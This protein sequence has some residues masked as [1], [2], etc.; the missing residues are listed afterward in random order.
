MSEPVRPGAVVLFGSGENGPVG[1]EA[2]RWLRASERDPRSVV[3]LETPA[4]FEVNA[5]AVAGKWARFLRR[6][7]ELRRAEVEQIPA[8]RRGTPFTPDDPD[9]ARP[10][11]GADLVVLGAG[12]PTYV[13]RQLRDS[14]AWSNTIA[15]HLLG[16][17]LFLASAAAVAAG[18]CALPVYEIYK[19]GEDPH[20][21]EGLRLFDLYGLRLAVVTHWDNAEGGTG[22]DTS[23]C[24]MGEARFRELVALLPDGVAVVGIDEH[25][26][27][28]VDPLAGEGHVV[29]RGEITVIRERREDTFASGAQLALAQLGPFARPGVDAV[30]P[31]VRAAVA[32]AR[33]EREAAR[34]PAEVDALMA[35]RQEARAK[36]DWSTAD[37]LRDEIEQRGWHLEDTPIG[38]RILPRR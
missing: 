12:S 34:P 8:R 5:E 24:Y 16:A 7:S 15:A 36:R 9:I 14:V 20:W 33:S 28:V 30:A 13:A 25:T 17:S 32:S 21:K 23:R 2:L 26:A 27:F 4:G 10:I 11:L 37:R 22:L 3:V 31:E 6:Q 18:T 1:R 29:G 38:T 19:V 35:K